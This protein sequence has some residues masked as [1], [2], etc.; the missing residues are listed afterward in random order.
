MGQ[1][2][3]AG[4]HLGVD[5]GLRGVDG[6]TETAH[7]VVAAERRHQHLP[8]GGHCLQQLGALVEVHA[9]LDRVHSVGD[10][11]GGPVQALDV[12]GHPEAHPVSLVNDGG[13][14]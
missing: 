1:L 14:L 11:R 3:D 9:V 6:V 8:A 4:E 5:R 12:G 7:P 10:G 2:D 13:E